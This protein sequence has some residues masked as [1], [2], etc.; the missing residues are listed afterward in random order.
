MPDWSGELTW[1]SPDPRGIL[2]LDAQPVSRTE[3]FARLAV[4]LEL[5]Q[6]TAFG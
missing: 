3:Y 4:A 5:L 1:W 2:P 6:P